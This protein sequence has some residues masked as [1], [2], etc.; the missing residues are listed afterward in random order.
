[1]IETYFK[2]GWRNIIRQKWFSFINV[3]GLAV[4]LAAAIM[5][6]IYIK[7]ETTYNKFHNDSEKIY[8]VISSFGPDANDALP[9]T[10]PGAAQVLKDQSPLVEQTVRIKPEYYNLR[11]GEKVFRGHTC[12]MTDP[13][14]AEIF[15]FKVISG[16]LGHTLSDPFSIAITRELAEVLFDRVDPLN[17]ILEIEHHFIDEPL[18]R[19]SQKYIPVKVGAVI[20]TLPKNSMFQFSVL[21][22]Y[23]SYDPT[24][25][26]TFSNDVFV[27]LKSK[28]V[29]SDENKEDLSAL[30][31][32]YT[33]TIYGE[34]YR[35]RIAYS[36]QALTDIHFGQK[37]GYDMGPRG[38][39]ELI[40]IFGAVALFILF[41]AIINFINLVTA[42]S[43]KR[44]V[45]AAIRKVSGAERYQ[46]ILQFLGEAVMISF[47]ALLLALL[48]SEILINP[49]ANLLNRELSLPDEL[50]F[51]QII[52]FISMAPL[53]GIL[54]GL[55]PAMLFA[56]YNPVQILRGKARGGSGNPMLRIFL[57]VIQFG[58]SVILIITIMVFNRQ[59]EYMK[60]TSLGFSAENVMVFGGL[61]DRLVNG[62]DALKSE[63]LMLPGVVKVSSSQ[64]YPGVS[65]S[66]M[67][68][69]R[70][71]DPAEM[72]I[73]ANEYRTS[74]DFQETF[75][76]KIKQGRWFDYDS[77]SDIQNFIVN[78]TAV[79]T[80][81]LT[82]P[83][84]QKVIM[85]Q[86]EGEIIGVAE[87]FHYSSLKNEI[88]PLVMSAYSPAFYYISVKLSGQDTQAT[89]EKVKNTLLAFDPNF[90]INERY[91]DAYFKA[92]Y[93]QEENNN[94]ILT[95]ASAL[96]VIIA[97]M[98]IFGLSSYIIVSR[99]KEIGVR[100]V[101]G[102]SVWQIIAVL[103]KDITRW[104]LLANLIAWPIAWW[105]MTNWLEGFPYRIHMS[106]WFLA[107][108]GILS[109]LI[110]AI[111]IS[112][113]TFMAA[114]KN[115]VDALRGE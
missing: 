40:Y 85:W 56:G 43:E 71:E 51:Q 104:V 114:R 83:I 98:G 95:F 15:D 3:F 35:E 96:A 19:M 4:G 113:Q 88:S 105:V 73:S 75:G 34:E 111:T 12:L 8:R 74:R 108:A 6:Y 112:G 78:E 100:K 90:N 66:G 9:R 94:K 79:K 109:M 30:I 26:R 5:L 80:L 87:D 31:K 103:F 1:M 7:H 68:L 81:G 42:R 21:Q 61:S 77:Q 45:E 115:P 63:L 50:S 24:V 28:N 2:S 101:M 102:A 13:S 32:T 22:S 41:I 92:L 64:A 16:D 57:V 67:S 18:R 47:M 23:E 97:M 69:R 93:K 14:F 62:F 48:F 59:I 70:A 106:V 33:L 52:I 17:Q 10:F 38:N 46:I 72:N 29:L 89:I 54:A 84:G 99:T 91:L 25:S 36:L 107:W 60:N 58:I 27:F 44:A 11:I 37:Y 39:K 86:R 55:Y 53:I 82:N 110:V 65:G 49:F 20:E 76:I